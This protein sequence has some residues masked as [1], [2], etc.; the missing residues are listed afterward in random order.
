MNAVAA[1]PAR[2]L[3]RLLELARSEDDLPCLGLRAVRSHLVKAFEVNG[4]LIALPL[5]GYKRAL[6]DGVWLRTDPGQVFLVPGPRVVDMENVP[7]AQSGEY[8]A[9]GITLGSNVLEAARQLIPDHPRVEPGPMAAVALDSLLEPLLAW[10]EAMHARQFTRACHAML[11]IVLRL[12]EMGYHGLLARPVPRLGERVRDLV[13]GEPAREWRSED[14][15]YALG[16]SGPTLRRHLAAEGTT[17]RE[18]IA[19]ARLAQA[20]QLLYS[21]RLPIKSVAQRVGYSSVSSFTK[22]FAQRYGMEPSR[23]GNGSAN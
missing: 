22:R 14:L 10:T 11:G 23:I 4:P 2:L 19:N 17:L 12:H 8:L 13:S 6:Q 1:A 16:M 5:Q 9:I 18:I 21:T 3:G 15:E 7:D 20:L